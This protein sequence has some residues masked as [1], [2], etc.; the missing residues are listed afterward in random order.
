MSENQE[1][2]E[3]E[4]PAAGEQPAGESATQQP[5]PDSEAALIAAADRAIAEEQA[6]LKA[7]RDAAPELDSKDVLLGKRDLGLKRVYVPHWASWVWLKTM[8]GEERDKFEVSCLV[9][10]KMTYENVRAKLLVHAIVNK[11]GVRLFGDDEWPALTK[12]SGAALGI[13]Y[14]DATKLN[15]ITEADVDELVKNS[16][17]G[18]T[19]TS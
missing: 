14:N 8:T 2:Q 13:L 15:A 6:R 18:T 16:G 19:A 7:E 12:K 9:N 10:G 11:D 3:Q 4:Q 1:P 5:A 17:S